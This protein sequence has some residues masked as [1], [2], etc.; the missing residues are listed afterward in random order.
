MH[1]VIILSILC[2]FITQ[3]KAQVSWDGG[4]DGTSWED[5]INWD[6]DLLPSEGDIIE[7]GTDAMISGVAEITPL[8]IKINGK[9]NVTLALDLNIGET[10]STEFPV[11]IGPLCNVYFGLENESYIFN[12]TSDNSKNGIANFAA[13]DSA[14]IV[15]NELTTI[16]FNNHSNAI[17][18][19]GPNTEMIN[20]GTLNIASSN[21][22]GLKLLG[23]F[24][25]HGIINIDDVNSDGLL[26]EGGTFD[27]QESGEIFVN[28]VLDDGIDIVNGGV[29]NNIGNVD[30]LLIE[31]A[32]SNNNG[33]SI[34]DDT[35]VGEFNNSGTLNVD[36]ATGEM[37]RGIS[38]NEEG[39]LSNSGYINLLGGNSGARLYSKK[40]VIND[41]NGVIQ[42]NDGRISINSGIITNAGY[43][44]STRDGAGIFLNDGASAVNYGFFQYFNSSQ[45]ASGNG[46]FEDYGE[47]VNSLNRVRIDINGACT[48]DIAETSYEYFLDGQA[49]EI[50]DQ[51]GM[52]VFPANSVL[53]DTV[54][55]T[56]TID[57]IEFRI[58]G[59][60]QDAI[61]SSSINDHVLDGSTLTIYPNLVQ[62][63]DVL[64]YQTSQKIQKAELVNMLGVNTSLIL[65]SDAQIVKLA[66]VNY[67][68]GINWII[69]TTKTN[70]TIIKP[71]LIK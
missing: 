3:M 26:I 50:S 69:F 24:S 66:D 20:Y 15:I 1:K 62:S 49:F 36:G 68:S 9:S 55:L 60:C 46:T 37:A 2:F 31:E 17:N 53:S 28:R 38:V 51:E 52:L 39:I 64:Q 43:I 48:V 59:V 18:I 25:N 10:N 65:D 6:G 22:T 8:Q 56:T 63:G 23:K 58:D 16:N 67:S 14:L 12:L 19:V 30:I 34:G 29:F 27:N 71:I 35:T 61:I 57:S 13:S 11:T 54:R 21:N 70:K 47:K 42:L 41:K 33:I 7:I 32:S 5:P 4:G 44:R 40:S 45:F